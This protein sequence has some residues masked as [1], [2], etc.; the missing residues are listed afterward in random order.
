MASP[1]AFKLVEG[2]D[3]SYTG[4]L[5]SADV[6]VAD[7]TIGSGAGTGASTAPFGADSVSAN[8]LAR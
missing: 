4:K 8:E 1:A 7:H 2:S 3:V 6:E 5:I